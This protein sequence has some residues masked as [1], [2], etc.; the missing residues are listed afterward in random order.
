MSRARSKWRGSVRATQGD[1]GTGRAIRI[2]RREEMN[3]RSVRLPSALGGNS[4]ARSF[5]K[6]Q[7]LRNLFF[8]SRTVRAWSP[9]ATHGRGL[10]STPETVLEQERTLTTSRTSG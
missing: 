5:P 1:R 2:D 3:G 8:D 4:R 6:W 7:S 9:T 10:P